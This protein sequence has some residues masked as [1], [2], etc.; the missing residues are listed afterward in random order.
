VADTEP[1]DRSTPPG[2]PAARRLAR[3]PG[4]RYGPGNVGTGT[5]GGTPAAGTA[6]ALPGP[7]VRA[8]LVSVAGAAALFVVGALLASTAGLLFTSGIT[9]AA[10]GLVLARA[11]LPRTGARPAGRGTVAWIA[12]TLALAA[13]TVAAAA[14]WLFARQEGGTLG[15]LDYLLEAFGPFIPGEAVIAAVAAAWGANAGPIQS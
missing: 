4:E 1:G 14:T 8:L 12:I 10:I 2:D 15:L 3:P 13:V 6:S 5:T 9:G 7:L 11:A